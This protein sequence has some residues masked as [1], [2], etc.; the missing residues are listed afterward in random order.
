MKRKKI[1]IDDMLRRYFAPLPREEVEAAGAEVLKRLRE[2]FPDRIEAFSLVPP[3]ERKVEEPDELMRWLRPRDVLVLNVLDSLAEESRFKEIFERVNAVAPVR[4]MATV[5]G[6][7]ER[8]EELGYVRTRNEDQPRPKG[9]YQI[10]ES[11]RR[12]AAK[13]R[14]RAAELPEEAETRGDLEGLEGLEDLI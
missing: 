13:A 10:T 11:G 7:L 4:H 5:Y 8:L 2:N 14:R 12:A 3:T 6:A 1:N 9:Y